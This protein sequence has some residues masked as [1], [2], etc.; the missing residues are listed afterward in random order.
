MLRLDFIP[1]PKLYT[2]RLCLR[3]LSMKDENEVFLLR[4]D[5]TVN[6]YLNRQPAKSIEDARRHIERLNE[7][8]AKKESIIWAITEKNS[9]NLLGSVCLWKISAENL[10]AEIGYELLPAQQGRGIMQEALPPVIKY[11]FEKMKLRSIEAELS[12]QNIKSIKLLENN[13][14]TLL[15]DNTNEDSLIYVSMNKS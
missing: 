5:E 14:F 15:V 12:P 4:S 8:F 10:K 1:F 2:E 3:Q 9:D 6:K 13:G 7:G 11:G